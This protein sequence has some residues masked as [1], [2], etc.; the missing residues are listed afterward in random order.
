MGTPEADIIK[1]Q[2]ESPSSL[3]TLRQGG[4]ELFPVRQVIARGTFVPVPDG[5]PE[6]SKTPL[7]LAWGGRIRVLLELEL[8]GQRP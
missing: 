4:K 8:W 2:V 5:R 7:E 6:V 1:G 3:R